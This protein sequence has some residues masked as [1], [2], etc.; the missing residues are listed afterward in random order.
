M[1]AFPNGFPDPYTHVV[2]FANEDRL[3][4]V[5]ASV[6]IFSDDEQENQEFR[7]ILCLWDSEAH[8]RS[9]KI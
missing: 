1:K 6:E 9:Q 4:F 2:S 7:D 5:T 3:S 8:I